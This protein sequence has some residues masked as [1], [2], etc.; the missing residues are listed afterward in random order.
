M[1][2]LQTFPQILVLLVGYLFG[3]IPTG[4][5][6]SR[7]C[8]LDD[9]RSIGSGNIGATNMLRL[10]DKKAALLTLLIDILKGSMAVV[11]ALIF[12]PAFAPWAGIAAVAGHIWPVWLMFRGGK[13]VA[14]SLGVILMLNWIL[15]L[16]CV[17]TWITFAIITRYSSLA[18]LVAF[19]LSSFYALFITGENLVMTCLIL[20]VLIFWTHHGN[21]QRLLKGKEPKIGDSTPPSANAN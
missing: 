19:L 17:G 6:V 18:S 3:S 21:I 4:I 1:I 5:I 2:T 10:G 14:T 20:T 15:A 11:F 9:P 8:H 16:A 12:V 13:G 7:L